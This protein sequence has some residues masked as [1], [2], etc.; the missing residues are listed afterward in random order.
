MG[1]RLEDTDI[2]ERGQDAARAFAA[3]LHRDLRFVHEAE[4]PELAT[5]LRRKGW[6]Y[7]RIAEALRMP[8]N[9][10][11]RW[12]SGPESV[13]EIASTTPQPT[14]AERAADPTQIEPLLA[15]LAALEQRLAEI[16][17]RLAQERQDA[18]ACEERLLTIIGE[19][20][21]A[22]AAAKP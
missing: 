19:L 14:R 15:R 12:L 10:V 1:A 11:S 16:D 17:R 21:A 7:R 5:A 2:D 13:V 4:K 22:I 3:T 18:K 8:Y 9:L 6:S 20:K